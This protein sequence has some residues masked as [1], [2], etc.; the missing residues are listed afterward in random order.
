MAEVAAADI[1]PTS[2]AV[3]LV[4]VYR[5]DEIRGSL[6]RESVLRGAP[7]VQDEK[8]RVPQILVEES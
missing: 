6:P 8:F 1:A 5:P 7:A 2:H 3:P 4:N